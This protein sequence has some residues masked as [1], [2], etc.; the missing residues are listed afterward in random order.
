MLILTLLSTLAAQLASASTHPTTSA[1]PSTLVNGTRNAP[2]SESSPLLLLPFFTAIVALLVT[3]FVVRCAAPRPIPGIPVAPGGLPCLGHLVTLL[4]NSSRWQWWKL[5]VLASFPP[6][7]TTPSTFQYSLIGERHP[8]I[9]VLSPTLLHFILHRSSPSFPKNMTRFRP[10]L[11]RGIFAANDEAW[12]TQRK[13]ITSLF[14]SPTFRAS[15]QTKVHRHIHRLCDRLDLACGSEAVDMQAELQRFTLHLICDVAFGD[16]A[17][18]EEEWE[19]FGEALD[20]AQRLCTG[21]LMEHPLWTGVKRTLDV[22]TERALR[23]HIDRIDSTIHRIVALK[24]KQLTASGDA[25]ATDVLRVYL[26]QHPR[27]TD[28]D[29]RDLTVNIIIAGRDTTAAA[30]TWLLWRLTRACHAAIFSRCLAEVDAVKRGESESLSYLHAVILETLR[31]HPPIHVQARQAAEEVTLPD[32]VVLPRGSY[33]FYPISVIQRLPHHFPQPHSFQPE[34]WLA[35][36]CSPTSLP[37]SSP[38]PSDSWHAGLCPVSPYVMLAFNAGRR[39]CVGRRL[40]LMEMSATC[41]A[42][43]ARYAFTP[44]DTSEG[45]AEHSL[46]PTRTSIVATMTHG[47]P[48]RITRR[49]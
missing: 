20:E 5:D 48:L 43:L 27:V 1:S 17:L 40:A 12:A 21:R 23:R 39:E 33:I 35:P 14:T 10:L 34:R 2:T 42:L 45:D 29:L 31:L 11:G 28:T 30:L 13:A 3:A 37:P 16:V 24:R 44:L 32:G 19:G 9:D 6:S 41:Q 8:L 47:L 25:D 36:L 38:P 26:Q 22:G 46:P 18:E 4:A 49:S 15:S 7:P